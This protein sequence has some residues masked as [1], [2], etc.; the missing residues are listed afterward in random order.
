MGF[1]GKALMKID[2]NPVSIF[3]Q[4]PGTLGELLLLRQ[5]TVAKNR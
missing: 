1:V 5:L 2:F 4:L 3:N